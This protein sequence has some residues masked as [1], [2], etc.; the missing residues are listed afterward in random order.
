VRGFVR[1]TNAMSFSRTVDFGDSTL[2]ESR[3]HEGSTFDDPPGYSPSRWIAPL[4]DRD[5]VIAELTK[6]FR[7]RVSRVQVAGTCSGGYTGESFEIVVIVL[8]VIGSGILGA[9]GKDI[10]EGIK[11]AMMRTVNRK[12]RRTLVEVAMQ[13]QECDVIL[14]AESR[15]AS[16]VPATFDD[17]DEFLKELKG[18]LAYGSALPQDAET[19]EVRVTSSAEKAR[20]V[21]Y[22][23]RRAQFMMQEI[24]S[25]TG[26]CEGAHQEDPR[27][28]AQVSA[29]KPSPEERVSPAPPAQ[30]AGQERAQ[31]RSRR[32]NGKR[33]DKG[34]QKNKRK[35]KK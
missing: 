6:S 15:N 8:G 12:P 4:I 30:P 18:R 23:Y 29:L 10:W 7:G 9:V 1:K 22:S 34:K 14:H 17:A 35:R 25:K 21:L 33:K 28:D 3:R 5:L 13:F 26:S 24:E 31:D 11:K 32:R 19:I 2:F 27:D 16:E 20:N